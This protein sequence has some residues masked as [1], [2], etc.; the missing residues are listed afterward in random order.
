MTLDQFIAAQR[1]DPAL[2]QTAAAVFRASDALQEGSDRMGRTDLADQVYR[3]DVD[4]QF[5]RGCGD[6]RLEFAAL[7]TI[8]GIQTE[9]GREASMV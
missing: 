5:E 2:R 3:A 7:Q 8:L 4:P 1:K 9:F 6:E